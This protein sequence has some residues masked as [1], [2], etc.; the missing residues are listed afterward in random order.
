M[1]IEVA[2]LEDEIRN[3]KSI[4]KKFK[5][6]DDAQAEIEHRKTLTKSSN[7]ITKYDK[8]LHNVKQP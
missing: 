1:P 2:D 5:Q 6:N 3:T 8:Q 4:A 7:L